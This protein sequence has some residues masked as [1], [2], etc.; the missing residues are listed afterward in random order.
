MKHSYL[1][2]TKDRFYF[3]PRRGMRPGLLGLEKMCFFV[4]GNGSIEKY[5]VQRLIHRL[6]TWLKP[7][8]LSEKC[9]LNIILYFN[10][11]SYEK[12]RQMA[13]YFTETPNLNKKVVPIVSL[14]L[15]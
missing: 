15:R 14:T 10:N 9:I 12:H 7:F 11:I 2:F 1:I 13:H 6:I 5:N 3:S 4:A 8:I